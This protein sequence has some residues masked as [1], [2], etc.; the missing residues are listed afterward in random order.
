MEFE[1]N[2]LYYK[3]KYLKY[4]SKYENLKSLHGGRVVILGQ[5]FGKPTG[6]RKR[7]KEKLTK[8][9]WSKKFK[10]IKPTSTKANE[11]CQNE[12]NQKCV[13]AIEEEL[14]NKKNKN[15]FKNIKKEYK[16]SCKIKT[17]DEED[18]EDPRIEKMH[19][20]LSKLGS[21]NIETNCSKLDK[22]EYAN[23][24]ICAS[25]T[26]RCPCRKFV[27]VPRWDEKNYIKNDTRSKNAVIQKARYKDYLRKCNDKFL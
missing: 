26:E 2:S 7:P 19:K 3:Q 6:S 11:S 23:N 17:K 12:T 13:I 16:K 25:K 27:V 4:K 5:S 18:E 24:W 9:K 21:K 1:P 22:K 15:F 8:S 14:K 10:E 20:E